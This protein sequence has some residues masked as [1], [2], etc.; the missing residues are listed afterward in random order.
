MFY[1]CRVLVLC[2]C[3]DSNKPLRVRMYTKTVWETHGDAPTW[4]KVVQ[5]RDSYSILSVL[6][7][8]TVFSGWQSGQRKFSYLSCLSSV[9]ASFSFRCKGWSASISANSHPS[10]VARKRMQKSGILLLSGV[11]S[12]HQPMYYVYD[13]MILVI[14]G[15]TLFAQIMAMPNSVFDIFLSSISRLTLYH[16]IVGSKSN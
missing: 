13:Y 2:E 9:W 7:I 4:S 14:V 3:D 8:H 5:S 12:I 16:S 15:I 10:L 6:Y 1:S 11:F